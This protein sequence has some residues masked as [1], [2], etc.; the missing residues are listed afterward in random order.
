MEY[1]ADIYFTFA[2]IFRRHKSHSTTVY[3]GFVG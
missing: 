1:A 2:T 3:K